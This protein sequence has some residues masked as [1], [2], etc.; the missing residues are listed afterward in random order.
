MILS[1]KSGQIKDRELKAYQGED[2]GCYTKYSKIIN[3]FILDG[4]SD[5]VLKIVFDESQKIKSSRSAIYQYL[6]RAGH[7]D[8]D[9]FMRGNAVYLI[10]RGGD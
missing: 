2:Y 9:V 5:N 4:N 1:V 8:V 6:H 7:L 3:D 10:K